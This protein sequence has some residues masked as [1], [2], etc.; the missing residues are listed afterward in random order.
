MQKILQ[1]ATKAG[2]LVLLLLTFHAAAAAAPLSA[3]FRQ[4]GN[5][6]VLVDV[7]GS[8][9]PCQTPTFNSIANLFPSPSG[10]VFEIPYRYL[11][12]ACLP[13]AV[14]SNWTQ[15]VILGFLDDGDYQVVGRESFQFPI[16]PY[17]PLGNFSIRGGLLI[18]YENVPVPVSSNPMLALL[19]TLLLA[20]GLIAHRRGPLV[21]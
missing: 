14:A 5:R 12:T 8:N 17:L 2:L 19:V 6:Q 1:F 15:T 4:L 10:N 16:L 20:V 21:R 18:V 13:N 3:K 11:N 7:S 9:V